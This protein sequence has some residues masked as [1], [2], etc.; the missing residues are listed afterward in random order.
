MR[1]QVPERIRKSVPFCAIFEEVSF[2]CHKCAICASSHEAV[3]FCASFSG[4]VLS[5]PPFANLCLSQ[6][7]TSTNLGAPGG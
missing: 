1:T 6:K 3:V 7:H 5:V 2:L 4:A